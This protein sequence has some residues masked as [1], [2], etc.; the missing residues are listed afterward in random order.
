MLGAGLSVVFP[1]SPLGALFPASPFEALSS[2][3]FE[4]LND[5]SRMNPGIGM[6]DADPWRLVVI[7]MRRASRWKFCEEI[8][9]RLGSDSGSGVPLRGGVL[10][11]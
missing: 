2:C 3:V 8:R 6:E 11:P 5:A 1:A 4:R 10:I 9:F 7:E